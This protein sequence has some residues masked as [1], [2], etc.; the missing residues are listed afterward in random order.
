MMSDKE[1]PPLPQA[2]IEGLQKLGLQPSVW[3]RPLTPEELQYLIDHCPFLQMVST[4]IIDPLEEPAF[5]TAKSGW[6]V[7]YYGD[8]MSSSPGHCLFARGFSEGDDDDDGAG[9]AGLGTIWKQAF[10]TAAEMVAYAKAHGWRGVH[11]IDG[12]PLMQWA[13]WMKA[14]DEGLAVEGYTPSEQALH[15]R[16]RVKRSEVEDYK[17]RQGLRQG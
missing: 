5:F 4:N 13:A 6:V 16:Q 11:V 8:A 17:L 2:V 1:N 12:H 15:K 14:S 7:H 10:D 9:G 3:E